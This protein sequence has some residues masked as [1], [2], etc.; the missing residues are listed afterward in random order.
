[1]KKRFTEGQIIGFLHETDG[2]AA[3]KENCHQHSISTLAQT[4]SACS[5][6]H[7]S[8]ATIPFWAVHR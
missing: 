3:V 6:L 2:G 4:S 5:V 7:V 1:M 8:R